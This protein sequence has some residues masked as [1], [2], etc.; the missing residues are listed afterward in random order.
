M[1]V[2]YKRVKEVLET[3]PF[4]SAE[5]ATIAK[6]E[7]YIDEEIINDFDGSYL[8]FDTRVLEF[9][10]NPDDE[11][12]YSPFKDIKSTRKSLMTKELKRRFEAVGWE[13]D[14]QQGEDDGPNRPAIDYWH[15]KGK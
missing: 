10:F 5:L 2:E 12:E 9:R 13:W 8:T 3:A 15:L 14:L 6:I 4:N 11:R 1:A 7:K